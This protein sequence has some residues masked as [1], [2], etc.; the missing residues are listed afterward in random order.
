MGNKTGDGNE[1]GQR[2]I[3]SN[4][5]LVRF[6]SVRNFMLKVSLFVAATVQSRNLQFRFRLSPSASPDHKHPFVDKRVIL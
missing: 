4:W 6:Q 3:I 1:G 5:L 2:P